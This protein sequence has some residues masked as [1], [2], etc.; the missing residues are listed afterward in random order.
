MLG[1]AGEPE[2]AR[3]LLELTRLRKPGIF[4]GTGGAT[5]DPGGETTV[6][7]GTMMH[8]GMEGPHLFRVT[9]PVR[10]AD[11]AWNELELYVRAHFG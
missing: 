1:A 8:P 4:S 9:V 11:G 10:G 5:I 2:F 7:Y 6:S 3:L